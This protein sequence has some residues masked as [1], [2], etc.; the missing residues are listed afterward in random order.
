[1]AAG[2]GLRECGGRGWGDGA[3][4]FLWDWQSQEWEL[5]AGQVKSTTRLQTAG[6]MTLEVGRCERRG[7]TRI[8]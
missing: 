2:G 7:G 1:A 8:R 5:R 4:R 3:N 6:I